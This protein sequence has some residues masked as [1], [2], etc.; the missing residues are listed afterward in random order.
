MI[1]RTV[2]HGSR[3]PARVK[4]ISAVDVRTWT[5][6][7][8]NHFGRLRDHGEEGALRALEGG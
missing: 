2:V 4:A 1:V 3:A 8:R 7:H 5:I 6:T